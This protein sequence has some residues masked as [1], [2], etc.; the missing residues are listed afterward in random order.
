[1]KNPYDVLGVPRNASAD[2]VKKAYRNL[3]RKYH[4]DANVNNPNKEAA[5][6]KFKEIQAAYQAIIDGK[7]DYYDNPQGYSGQGYGSAYGGGYGGQRGQGY[8]DYEDFGGFGSFGGFGPF[9]FG[10]FYSTGG[11]QRTRNESTEDMYFRAVRNY[12]QSGHYREA[13]TALENIQERG[14]SW[15]YYS[16]IANMGLGNQATAL[17]HIQT[18]IELEPDNQQY[19]QTYSQFQSGS[20]WYSGMGGAYEM[21]TTSQ[22]GFCLRLCLANLFCNCFCGP[23]ICC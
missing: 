2:E 3:S 19:R 13:L 22:G 7:A 8:S 11:R 12:I 4:P 14:G 18:A 23:G 15:Y 10:G 1:M 9:G 21:P 6:E 17:E 20:S 16:S 5:E